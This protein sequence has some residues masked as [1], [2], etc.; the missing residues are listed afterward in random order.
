MLYYR[1]IMAVSSLEINSKDPMTN[2]DHMTFNQDVMGSN[3]IA[4]TKGTAPAMRAR[5]HC[6]GQ[7]PPGP[8][9]MPESRAGEGTSLA[10]TVACTILI[11]YGDRR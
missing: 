10:V 11:A 9:G 7:L 4:L 8:A 1:V 2:R 3:P 6:S 5:S